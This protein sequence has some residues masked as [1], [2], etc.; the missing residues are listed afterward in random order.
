MT[1]FIKSNS[2]QSGVTLVELL[3]VIVVI[4]IL[5]GFALLQRGNANEQLRRQNAAQQLKV[6][7][8]R[9]R[10]DSVK[11]RAECDPNKAKVVISAD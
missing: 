3:V 1:D 5:A 2:H 9:A 4:S 11:R 7:F 6:A 10:F 8:E